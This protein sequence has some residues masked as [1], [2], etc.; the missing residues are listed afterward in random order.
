MN[1]SNANVF[2]SS[3]IAIFSGMIA[4]SIVNDFFSFIHPIT[5][6]IFVLLV[7]IAVFWISL[8]YLPG[9]K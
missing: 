5:K 1:L 2:C 9:K 3:L 8:K 4:I 7:A 6:F